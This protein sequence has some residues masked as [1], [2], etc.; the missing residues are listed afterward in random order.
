MPQIALFFT[1]NGI[2]YPKFQSMNFRTEL[3]PLPAHWQIDQN[4]RVLTVGSCFAEVMGQQLEQNKLCV[5]NNPF[6][7]TFNPHSAVKLL[8][9]SLENKTIDDTMLL[10]NQGIW[11]HYDFH[12]SVWGH[13]A[14]ACRAAAQQQISSTHHFLQNTDLLVVT[15]GTAFVY[16]HAESGQIVSNCHKMPAHL[17]KKQLLS[18][19][20][21]VG[22]FQ[23]FYKKLGRSN[24]NTILTVSP[25]RH[26]RDTLPL[27]QV[28]KSTLRLACHVLEQTLP[29]CTYF[30]SYELMLDDLRDYRFYKPDLIHPNEVAEKYIFEKFS[31]SYFSPSFKTFVAEWQKIRQ[32]LAHRPQH[33][34]TAAHQKF[35]RDLLEKLTAL[36]PQIDVTAEI[37]AVQAQL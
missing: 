14:T 2:S 37:A 17:F 31:E 5:L 4:T 22:T 7:T 19:E 11:F 26:T 8:S 3:N 27:N 24:L 18:V 16:R 34:G 33:T 1:L 20:E 29:H 30:P 9:M 6:S 21:I 35:L 36:S 23:E 32:A 15:L 25:V 28:S 12:S 10:K 13:D